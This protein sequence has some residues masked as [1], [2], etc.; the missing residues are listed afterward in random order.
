VTG[1]KIDIAAHDGG[2]FTGYLATPASGGGPGVLVIQEI[3]GVNPNIRAIADRLA[4]NGFF[5]LAPDLFWRQEAGVELDPGVQADWDRAFKFYQGFDNDQGVED[6]KSAMKSLHALKGATGKVGCQGYCLGGLLAY[7][8]AARTD[9]DAAVGYYGVGING[10]VNE[11]K[12]IK[13]PLM[14]HIAQADAFV[15]AAAQAAVHR[16]LDGNSLVT[17]HDYAGMNHAFARPGGDNYDKTQ[18]DLA[19]RRSLEFLKA[20]LKG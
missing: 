9:I 8:M 6:L 19:D 12:N 16:A 13:K 11:A 20:H 1:K 3:F 2:S 18:A 15:D 14:L 4:A 10:K 5:A 17:L 7:L